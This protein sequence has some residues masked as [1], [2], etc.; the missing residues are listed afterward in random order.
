MVGC[1]GAGKTT[2]SLKLGEQLGLPVHHLDAIYWKPGWERTERDAFVAQQQRILDEPQW[3]VDGNNR[4]TIE[5]RLRAADTIVFLD[6]PRRVCLRGAITRFLAHRKTD[7]PDKRP[8]NHERLSLEY[9][10]FIWR[11]PTD[12]RPGVVALLNE[13]GRDRAVHVLTSRRAVDAFVATVS[14]DG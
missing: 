8:G 2:I 6:L 14:R 10:R 9:L 5:L 3:I 13:L 12:F 11:Y 4:S 1:G 7:R